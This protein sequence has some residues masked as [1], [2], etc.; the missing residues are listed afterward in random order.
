MVDD[1]PSNVQPT[2]DNDEGSAQDD[3]VCTPPR[4]AQLGSLEEKICAGPKLR[5]SKTPKSV[6][7][8]RRSERLAMKP[9]AANATLQA[10]SVL[11][12]KLGVTV[13][14]NAMDAKALEKYR[15]TFAA[16][17]STSKQ[18]ALQTLFLDELDLVAM[19]LDLAGLDVEAI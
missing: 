12:Q 7:T 5:K 14:T 17:L 13:N 18:E 1:P 9:R 3:T 4:L 8:P 11:M 10:Q 2:A 19:N 16:P 6:L 15:A